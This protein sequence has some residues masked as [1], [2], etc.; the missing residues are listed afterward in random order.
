MIVDI[1]ETPRQ[2]KPFNADDFQTEGDQESKTVG[3]FFA[4]SEIEELDHETFIE[5][6]D[7]AREVLRKKNAGDNLRF[8]S[9]QLDHDNQSVGFYFSKR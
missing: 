3:F 6:L 1:A 5:T 8:E 9:M 2:P 7:A 4:M